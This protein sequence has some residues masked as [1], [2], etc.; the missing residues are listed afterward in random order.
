[1]HFHKHLAGFQA[2][3]HQSDLL[4]FHGSQKETKEKT[5]GSDRFSAA[6]L[7]SEGSINVIEHVQLQLAGYM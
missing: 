6:V 5:R 2:H 7:L 4:L 3:N 1:M